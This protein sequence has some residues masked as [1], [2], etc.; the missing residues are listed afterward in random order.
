[1]N[2]KSDIRKV[3]FTRFLDR[4]GID[5]NSHLSEIINSSGRS[6]G[7][8]S[9]GILKHKT[10][11]SAEGSNFFKSKNTS[12]NSKKLKNRIKE[13]KLQVYPSLLT[14]QD[15]AKNMRSNSEISGSVIKPG[16]KSRSVSRSRS[17]VHSN[18][19]SLTRNM[20]EDDFETLDKVLEF[21]QH[22][23]D[24]Y[25]ETEEQKNLS[26]KVP[27]IGLEEKSI[28]STAILSK[29]QEISSNPLNLK[30]DAQ[31]ATLSKKWVNLGS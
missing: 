15:K 29:P 31:T 9:K 1:M 14:S 12:E 8:P 22:H 30:S 5:E 17:P 25:T 18:N 19:S 28:G 27:R 7:V 16:A 23:K 2:Q 4:G 24:D 3:N 6:R 21:Y 20:V 13:M 11:N 26:K 10:Q